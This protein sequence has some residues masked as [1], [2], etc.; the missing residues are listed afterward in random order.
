MKLFF[1]L[2]LLLSLTGCAT[3]GGWPCWT[4]QKNTD[5]KNEKVGKETINKITRTS[6]PPY[7]PGWTNSPA[8]TNQWPKYSAPFHI[9]TNQMWL[10][11]SNLNK[12]TISLTLNHTTNGRTNWVEWAHVLNSDWFALFMI[13]GNGGNITT[14]IPKVPNDTTA[15]YRVLFP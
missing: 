1:T 12:T 10:S 7:P 15:F 13:K 14:N 9:D 11:I 2:C 6:G 4:W 8:E 5:Q 3:K